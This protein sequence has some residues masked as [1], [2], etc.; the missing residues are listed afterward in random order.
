MPT[1]SFP[2]RIHFY[3]VSIPHDRGR[4]CLFLSSTYPPLFAQ[5]YCSFPVAEM[6]LAFTVGLDTV[7][8]ISHD[9]SLTAL[10]TLIV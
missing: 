7:P 5:T 9:Q 1:N 4:L 8:V 3:S 2:F 10:D 6:P